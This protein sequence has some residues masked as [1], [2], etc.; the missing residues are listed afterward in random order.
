MTKILLVE[1]DSNLREIYA[2]S[3]QAEGYDIVT[4][5][6]G[7]Q[8]LAVAIRERPDLVVLDVMMPKISG[9]D[10]L[11]ILRAT[12]E[13]KHAKII[14]MTALSQ[15][16]DRERGVS[17]GADRYLIKSQITLE[18]LI[19][20][21]KE[22]V[23]QINAP[24]A[25]PEAMIASEAPKDIYVPNLP[26]EQITQPVQQPVAAP[27]LQTQVSPAQPPIVAPGPSQV[28]PQPA[29]QPQQVQQ[30]PIVDPVAVM[31]PQQ[32]QAVQA[33]V[34]APDPAVAADP[35]AGPDPSAVQTPSPDNTPIH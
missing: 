4:A 9:F 12:P 13:T 27:V 3:I 29:P 28:V 8:A 19:S 1:D 30:Q 2:A 7:E 35:V 31:P 11:D 20:N 17:L 26:I 18:D 5:S 25:V 16:T 32:P 21:I 15:Q 22:L 34:S 10:V 33:P 14:M 24:V 23:S 6:D